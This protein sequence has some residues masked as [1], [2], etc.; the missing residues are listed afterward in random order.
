MLRASRLV[1]GA[2]AVMFGGVLL[3][4][5]AGAPNDSYFPLKVG[6]KWTYKVN[7]SL[8]EVRVAKAEK[9]GAEEQYVV[10]TTV[11]KDAKT[12]EMYVVRADGVYRTKV[13]DDK[14]DPPVKILPLPAKKDSWEVNSK[15]GT[16]SVKGT[17]KVI[18]DE[19]LKV[20]GTEYDTVQ[21]EGKDLEVAGAKAN[22]NVWFAKG[23]GIV[24]EVFTLANGD[25]VTLELTKYEEGKDGKD[26][27]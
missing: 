1:L 6:S 2:A 22:M 26:G 5:P 20:Q 9:V 8:V 17:L 27:K 4:Q 16:Q 18:G 14:L 25:K 24:K 7:D 3:A 10:E 19:K 23:R 15:L 13:K 12:A 11:G 21:V